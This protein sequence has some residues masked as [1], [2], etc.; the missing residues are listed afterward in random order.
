MKPLPLLLCALL[1]AG[2]YR[3]QRPQPKTPPP[4]QADAVRLSE[5]QPGEPDSG[6]VKVP[7]AMT[8]NRFEQN[9]YAVSQGKTLF[10]RY[11]CSGCHGQGGGGMGPALMDDKWRYGSAPAQIYATI[12]QGR[13]NGMP[14]FAGHLTDEQIWQL[15]AYVRSM[16]GQLRIDVAPSRG[17]DLQ[18][19]EPEGRRERVKPKSEPG[20]AP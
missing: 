9:A 19:G 13:P 18:S 5:L 3:E 16:S 7:A 15:A 10:K 20:G 8:P 11:N 6:P 14:S 1:L 12:A 4:A 17:E 2:C